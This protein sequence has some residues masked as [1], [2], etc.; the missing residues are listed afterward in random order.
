MAA[1]ITAA[2]IGGLVFVVISS[3][4]ARNNARREYRKQQQM[5]KRRG[6]GQEPLLDPIPPESNNILLASIRDKNCRR[7]ALWTGLA[8]L[9]GIGALMA[10]VNRMFAAEIAVWPKDGVEL[11]G[12]IVVVRVAN[13]TITTGM[14]TREGCLFFQPVFSDGDYQ[15]FVAKVA[16]GLVQ[17]SEMTVRLTSNK[18]KIEMLDFPHY[19]HKEIKLPAV[20]F[21]IGS[22]KVSH[23]DAKMLNSIEKT[24]LEKS[25]MILVAG[26]ADSR[27]FPAGS[28][29]NN[30]D[31]S[32]LRCQSV[33]AGMNLGR[34]ESTQ[35]IAPLDNKMPLV[36]NAH[37]EA[38]MAPDRSVTLIP[39]LRQNEPILRPSGK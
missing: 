8:Y 24:L 30:Y 31:L 36:P 22:N 4:H 33:V 2:F 37:T 16:D 20:L 13:K 28:K 14:L 29:S 18:S 9:A 11:S 34:P 6:R 32:K 35:V 38:E 17:W 19:S 3:K 10:Y 26:R 39:L 12:A 1:L 21:G 15:V 23:L 5:P 25:D 7:R 27:E